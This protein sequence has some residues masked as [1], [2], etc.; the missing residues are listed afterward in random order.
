MTMRKKADPKRGRLL[1]HLIGQEIK[2]LR[3]KENLTQA[4]LAQAVNLSPGMLCKLE[5]GLTSSSLETLQALSEV[6][7]VPIATFF[8][9]YDER[10]SWEVGRRKY[11]TATTTT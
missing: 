7:S 9:R 10:K 2:R 3:A 11:S 1:Q 6:L 5:K 8:H 4:T